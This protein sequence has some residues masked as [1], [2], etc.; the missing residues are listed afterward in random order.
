VTVLRTSDR[1]YGRSPLFA[2]FATIFI[3]LVGLS[4]LI[5]VFPVLIGT[6]ASQQ[7]RVTPLS[8]TPS[9][10]LIMLGWLQAIYP[11]CMFLAAPVLGQLSDRV[12]RRPVLALSLAGTAIGYAI[13]AIGI[14]TKNSRRSFW[15]GASTG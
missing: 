6:A 2:V 5:P 4:I 13:F 12:G 15:G 14:S 11:L 8:W 7:Y 9:Q 10:G 1:R 3:D